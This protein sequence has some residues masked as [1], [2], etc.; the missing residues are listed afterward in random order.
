MTLM[1]RDHTYLLEYFFTLR[2][3]SGLKDTLWHSVK[4]HKPPDLRVAYWYARQE[5]Q[6]YLSVTKKQISVTVTNRQPPAYN[7]N[8]PAPNRE[9]RNRPQLDK[10]KEKGQC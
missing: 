3:I 1:K 7:V 8:R 5:D 2:F 6:A 9:T 10:Q 4:T